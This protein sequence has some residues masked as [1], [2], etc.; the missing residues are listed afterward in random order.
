MK[1]DEMFRACSTQRRDEKYVQNFGW[2]ALKDRFSK[3]GDNMD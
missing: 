1:E 2:K 3:I